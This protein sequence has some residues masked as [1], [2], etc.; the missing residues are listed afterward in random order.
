[1]RQVRQ[2]GGQQTVG[3]T[4]EAKLLTVAVIPRAWGR[5]GFQ[6]EDNRHRFA[7]LKDHPFK[8]RE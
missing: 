8:L 2:R 3:G 5:D 4:S 6:A 1:M 7:L